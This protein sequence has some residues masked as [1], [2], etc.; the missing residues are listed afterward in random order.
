MEKNTREISGMLETFYFL[1]RMFVAC[2]CIFVKIHRI[3]H[4]RSVNSNAHIFYLKIN[5]KEKIVKEM[6]TREDLSCSK[7]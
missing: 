1:I 5:A 4:L 3:V 7:L 6:Y 2:V